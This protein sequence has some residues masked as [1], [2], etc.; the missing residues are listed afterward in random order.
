MVDRLLGFA[1]ENLLVA[2][3]KGSLFGLGLRDLMVDG[4]LTLPRGGFVLV[5]ID[6]DRPPLSAAATLFTEPPSRGGLPGGFCSLLDFF[7]NIAD[8]LVQKAWGQPQD[9]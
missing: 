7:L 8:G 4:R 2:S 6:M 9:Q 5:L 3:E 1:D